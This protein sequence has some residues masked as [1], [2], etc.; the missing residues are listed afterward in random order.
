MNDTMI[1]KGYVAKVEFDSL[2]D[3]FVGHVL[4][5]SELICFHGT[6]VD[7]LRTAFHEMIEHYLADCKTKGRSPGRQIEEM[8]KAAS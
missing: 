1:Y 3:I 5:V 8:G 2:D 7:E 6:S 4:D